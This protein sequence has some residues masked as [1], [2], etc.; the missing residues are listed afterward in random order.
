MKRLLIFFKT[1]WNALK[2]LFHRQSRFEKLLSKYKDQENMDITTLTQLIIAFR[3]ETAQSS[4]TP[5]SLG[6]LLQKIVNLLGDAAD[7]STTQVLTEWMND[8]TS[9]QALV[10]N[11]RAS[12][13]NEGITFYMDK[14]DAT[15]GDAFTQSLRITYP[16]YTLAKG[17]ANGYVQL[18]LTDNT[19]NEVFSSVK[20]YG[21]TNTAAGIMTAADKTKLEN[22]ASGLNSL[23]DEVA[24]K[25]TKNEVQPIKDW[26]DTV[27]GI[28]DVVKSVQVSPD[29]TQMY[30]RLNKA[31]LD[32]GRT[33]VDN[34]LVPHVSESQAGVMS[35]ADYRNLNML[36]EKAQEEDDDDGGQDV[37]PHSDKR[38]YYHIEVEPDGDEIILKY[39]RELTSKGYVPYLYRWTVKNATHKRKDAP[40]EEK[41]RTKNRRGWH[42]FYGQ[43]KVQLASSNSSKLLFLTNTSN[44]D[45]NGAIYHFNIRWLLGDIRRENNLYKIGFG[46][47]TYKIKANH[48]FKFGV[49]FAPPQE[50]GQEGL[51]IHSL[52]TNIA[53]FNIMFVVDEDNNTYHIHPSV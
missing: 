20:I 8:L 37:T 32:N 46:K 50:E 9:A 26:K 23:A 21:A 38:P 7:A 16:K 44:Q 39:D 15:T 51:P 1:V 12:A 14:V 47:K 42:L 6:S 2:R 25:A 19:G 40:A 4:I 49:A 27:S 24:L 41:T 22:V 43:R 48:R 17:T 33:S 5:E 29:N 35:A 10:K 36:V 30:V 53:P 3:Q 13:D 34:I 52:V 31:S 28:G 45:M 18:S 11:I